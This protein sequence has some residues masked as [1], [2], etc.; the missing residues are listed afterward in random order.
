MK[1][2]VIGTHGTGKST[3]TYLLASH[4]KKI[5]KNVKIIQE[6]ARNCP[7]PINHEMK[8]ET[9]FWIFHEQCKKELEAEKNHDIVICDRT[10]LDSF[11]YAEYFCLFHR[12][13]NDLKKVALCK[14][15]Y[16][17]DK[18]FFIRPN[19]PLISDGIRSDDLEFQRGI[20]ELFA[21]YLRSISYTELTSSE[22]FSEGSTWKHF[23]L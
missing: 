23:C 7:F 8:I 9:C 22:I 2:A 6:T 16:E 17:Y 19:I 3:L 14:L 5:G 11:L 18:I 12:N 13:I 15:A 10:C 21:H 4:Y 20:D 1:I